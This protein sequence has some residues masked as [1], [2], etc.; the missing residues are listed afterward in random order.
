MQV[1]SAPGI[2]TMLRRLE[3]ETQ[4]PIQFVDITEEVAAIRHHHP[5]AVE[6]VTKGVH[7]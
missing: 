7:S 2:T 4:E 1:L 5:K 6:T 3:L